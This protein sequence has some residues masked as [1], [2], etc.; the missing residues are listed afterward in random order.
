M[1]NETAFTH[2]TTKILS[3]VET[4]K[5]FNKNK[6]SQFKTLQKNKT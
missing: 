4:L 2:T 1:L 6:P 5:F 3:A